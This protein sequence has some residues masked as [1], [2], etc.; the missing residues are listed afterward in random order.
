MLARNESFGH[1]RDVFEEADDADVCV[2]MDDASEYAAAAVLAG[3][4][5]HEHAHAALMALRRRRTAKLDRL[6]SA[7]VR[8][9]FAR[10]PVGQRLLREELIRFFDGHRGCAE[11]FEDRELLAPDVVDAMRPSVGLA[12]ACVAADVHPPALTT[13]GE[14]SAWLGLYPDQ[15]KSLVAT[16]RGGAGR[17]YLRH[18]RARR[19]S[20]PRLL[21]VP[22]SD[23]RD[24]QQRLLRDL[25]A[26]IPV[27]PAACAFVRGRGVRDAVEP[28]AE[29]DVVLRL[30]V[31][32]FFASIGRGRVLRAFLN[33]GYPDSVADALARLC[34]VATPAATLASLSPAEGERGR[35]HARLRERLRV[36]HLPQGSATSPALANLCCH[37]VDQRLTG[38]AKRFGARY[39]RYADDLIFS[40]GPEFARV[41]QR[42][43][44]RAA[45]IL[46]E[47]RLRV[48]HRKTRIMRQGTAQR[49][50]GLV[51][52]RAPALPRRERKLLE[53][54]LHNCV[55]QGPSTQ[56][57]AGVTQFRAHL[58]GRVAHAQAFAGGGRSA[59]R[60]PELLAQIDWSR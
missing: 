45:A 60:L 27:H 51:L 11:A 40:G 19:R 12:S 49:A 33:F 23:L 25:L 22:K 15:L 50:C 54:I 36:P 8:D 1:D 46:L 52:N 34:T 32:D 28:H 20:P 59:R 24:V 21:E 7:L 42:F 47:H 3:P 39:T 2:E 56:N 53:A 55:R 57:R 31:E 14:L 41:S 38:I 35:H 18:W 16:R 10:F 13:L 37:A 5:T 48:A 26:H 4:F 44:D 6:V 58:E 29:R 30:D 9:L 17:H 43:A